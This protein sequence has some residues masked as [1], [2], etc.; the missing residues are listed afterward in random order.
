MWVTAL[1]SVGPHNVDWGRRHVDV[2]IWM[3][4]CGCWNVDVGCGCWLWT[5]E[6]GNRTGLVW[7]A[8][9]DPEV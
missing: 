6:R 4:K 8:G 7:R 1:S 3:L 2:G 9:P 5:L